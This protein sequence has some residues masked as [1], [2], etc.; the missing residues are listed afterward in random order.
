MKSNRL[1]LLLL[2]L[3]SALLLQAT[4][5]GVLAEV[6]TEVWCP[7]CPDA[8]SGLRDLYEGHDYVVPLIW[9]GDGD[10]PSPNYN[11]R[12]SFYG[13]DGLPDAYFGGTEN[14][15]GGGTNMYPYYR[16]AYNNIINDNSPLDIDIELGTNNSGQLAIMANVELTGDITTTNNRIIY[17]LTYAFTEEYFCTVVEYGDETFSLNETGETGYY[18]HPVELDPT[19]DL[20]GLRA[21]VVVQ[22]MSG[23]RKVHQAVSTMFTGT[24]AVIS[25]SITSGPANLTVSF[26]SHSFPVGEI[27]AWEWDFNGD[28]TIDSEEE[29]TFWIY[30]TPGTYDVSLTIY[31]ADESSTTTAEGLITVT[32]GSNVSGPVAGSWVTTYSPY[33]IVGDVSVPDG[34]VL[35][36]DPGVEIILSNDALFEVNGRI[37]ANAGNGDPIMF[38]PASEGSWEGFKIR[39]TNQDNEFTNCRFTGATHSAIAVDGAPLEVDGCWFYGNNSTSVPAA[40]DLV[41][42]SDVSITGCLFA[43]N[44]S[45]GNSGAIQ[46]MTSSAEITN[47]IFVNNTGSSAGA[48]IFKSGSAPTFNNNT[49]A[50]NSITGAS[51]GALFTYNASPQIMNCIVRGEGSMLFALTSTPTVDFTNIQGGWEGTM[52]IDVDPLFTMPSEGSGADYDGL[53]ARWFLQEE[54]PCIDAGYPTEEF[55]DV[56][57]PDN[58]GYALWPAM[59]GLTNDM[60]AYGGAGAPF[61]DTDDEETI[62]SP[63]DVIGLHV[64]PNPFN[65]ETTIQLQL[66]AQESQQP[67]S[68]AIYNIRGQKVITLLDNEKPQTTGM[69]WKGIDSTGK[70][71]SSGVYFARM[72]AGK[73]TVTTRMALIK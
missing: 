40:I 51:G 16:S 25:P 34:Q 39:Y 64:Y 72:T 17:I 36:I 44:T 29:N 32:N 68:L 58:P 8:R 5:I 45:T 46:L 22:T 50:N 57:D 15:G 67:V 24:L 71:V 6:F 41:S 47:N 66:S 52:N 14:V 1:L 26:V 11:S 48:A 3:L 20:M 42:T 55:N 43:N 4:Q 56:E 69:T 7:Y 59:G 9:E 54:S 38:G 63:A 27:T 28:G 2:M 33:E 53:S 62:V 65:P 23:T 31:T 60:G 30:D 21:I 12:Y 18:E 13:V 10:H 61:V 19:W 73:R 70:S 49:V 37:V 35:T